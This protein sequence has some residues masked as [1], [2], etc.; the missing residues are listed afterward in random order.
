M[1]HLNQILSKFVN[2][3]AKLIRGSRKYDTV[4]EIVILKGA[5]HLK[6]SGLI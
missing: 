3:V 2:G 6:S 4:E 1:P 5:I